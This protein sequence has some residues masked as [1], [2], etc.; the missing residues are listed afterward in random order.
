[1]K[2]TVYHFKIKRASRN[3]R[4]SDILKMRMQNYQQKKKVIN[5]KRL[6]NGLRKN[7]ETALYLSLKR[8]N[9]FEARS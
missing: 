9:N 8:L 4:P 2:I 6:R 1:L 7:P 5:R 3:I